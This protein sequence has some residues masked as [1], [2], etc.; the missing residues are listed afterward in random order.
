[1]RLVLKL[2]KGVIFNANIIIKYLF[3]TFIFFTFLVFVVSVAEFLIILFFKLIIGL[4]EYFVSASI[5]GKFYLLNL[6]III[7]YFLL[8]KNV[9]LR[10]VKNYSNKFKRKYFSSKNREGLEKY[11]NILFLLLLYLLICSVGIKFHQFNGNEWS[12]ENKGDIINIFIWTTYLIAPIVAIW[13]YSDWREPHKL[14]KKLDLINEIEN[15]ILCLERCSRELNELI[16]SY[17]NDPQK[18]Y[19]ELQLEY[20]QFTRKMA[21][22]EILSRQLE[23]NAELKQISKK[24]SNF[25]YSFIQFSLFPAALLSIL[26]KENIYFCE[27]NSIDKS[28]EDRISMLLRNDDR[29]KWLSKSYG[30]IFE[31]QK[32]LIFLKKEYIF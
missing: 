2:I 4:R 18:P 25:N 26:K 14:N 15:Q 9:L 8:N 16:N 23:M 12:E 1:M 29:E 7:F 17:L 11:K 5:E 10:N 13:V 20:N 3:I 22:L 32:D 27:S 30:D 6:Y 19:S 24:L 21:N 28:F 31:I